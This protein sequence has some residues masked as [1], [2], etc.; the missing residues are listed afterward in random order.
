MPRLTIT[1]AAT[2]VPM[3]AQVYEEQV[4]SRAA[5]ALAAHGSWS[6]DRLVV[7]SLRSPLPG[8]RRLPMG[9]LAGAS[10]RSRRAVGR[11]LYPRGGVVH[12]MGLELPPSPH[13]DV[14][15][16]HDV[17]A[18]KFPDESAPVP[19]A[20]QE[21]RRAAAVIC[22]SAFSAGEAVDLLGID[23]PHV[24]HNGVDPR[25]LDAVPLGSEEL[26]ALGITGPYVLTA[27]GVSRRKNLE[28]LAEAWPRIRSA[29]PD[30][31]LVLAGPEHPKR[32]ALF[33]GL[34]GVRLVGR[35]PDATIAGL[36]AAASAVLVPSLY[37][38]F[39]LPALEAMAAGVPVVAARTSSLPE[40]VGDGGMLVEPTVEQIVEGT[41]WALSDDFAV[42]EMAARGRTRAAEFTW[43]RA[44]AGHAA[45]WASLV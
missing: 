26:E 17:V 22:V 24:V 6:V 39:G 29:R 32:T 43:E 23:P 12:R 20:A 30:V 28:G 19:A 4:A 42:R 35:V 45:V 3:G 14:I 34:P 38:G 5:A 7:R 41:L 2:A 8:N 15:T 21:A 13:L 33:G 10:T 36:Y 27:G 18:W 16:L 37:E 1:G 31:T 25:Y 11:A 44:A 40:V 9:W